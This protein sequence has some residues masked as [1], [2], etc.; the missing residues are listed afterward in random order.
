MRRRPE[1]W[2]RSQTFFSLREPPPRPRLT[3]ERAR[4]PPSACLHV[5]LPTIL[6]RSSHQPP[7]ETRA[8]SVRPPFPSLPRRTVAMPH[9][10]VSSRDGTAVRCPS[11]QQATQP[12]AR[13]R[14]RHVRCPR[15][16]FRSQKT[17]SGST[18]ATHLV[19]KLKSCFLKNVWGNSVSSRPLTALAVNRLD[20]K[21]SLQ[22][23]LLFL[24]PWLLFAGPSC[25]GTAPSPLQHLCFSQPLTAGFLVP[26][27][28][29]G[30][31]WP[32]PPI[33]RGHAGAGTSHSPWLFGAPP[34]TPAWPCFRCGEFDLKVGKLLPSLALSQD[35]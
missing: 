31:C 2:I 4:S 12:G 33:P 8:V 16:A 21:D 35:G 5:C 13:T 25:V 1:L 11:G 3:P 30:G 32:A 17:N 14:S 22:Q 9:L 15:A 23:P 28:H 19:C 27:L 7:G 26:T 10:R 6:Q 34:R 29:R 24:P 20:L 18:F